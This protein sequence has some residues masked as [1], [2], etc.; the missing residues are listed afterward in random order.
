MFVASSDYLIRVKILIEESDRLDI[1]VAFWGDGSEALLSPEV[2]EGKQVRVLCNLVSGGTNPKPIA[3]LLKQGVNIQ[4]IDDLHAKVILGHQSAIVGSANFSTNGLQLEGDEGRGWAEAGLATENPSDIQTISKW[5][6]SQWTRSAPITPADLEAASDAW[7][8]RRVARQV[9]RT[10]RLSDFTPA[11]V[12][13]R[14]LFVIIWSG[15][16]S[17]GAEKACMQIVSDAKE[18]EVLPAALLE[19]VSYY[20]GWPQL[21]PEATLISFQ[22]HRNGKFTCDGV[23]LRVP[24]LDREA[25]DDHQGLQIVR[26]LDTVLNLPVTTEQKKDFGAIFK[27]VLKE[28]STEFEGGNGGAIIPLDQALA[29]VHSKTCS[30]KARTT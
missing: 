29:R 6:A 17:E 16:P 12:K 21:P 28:L 14:N 22:Q 10:K 27:P 30:V 25:N 20:E 26:E 5:F 23:W 1:A 11:E 19:R 18:D 9:R 4:M 15:S 8:L 24:F 13:D 7:K 2:I 3:H